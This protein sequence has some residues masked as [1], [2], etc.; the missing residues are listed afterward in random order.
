MVFLRFAQARL[1]DLKDRAEVAAMVER[2]NHQVRPLQSPTYG[3]TII[4]YSSSSARG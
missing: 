2:D 3:G 1:G 4:R